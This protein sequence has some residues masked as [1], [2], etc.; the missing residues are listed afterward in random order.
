MVGNRQ[1]RHSCQLHRKA[2]YFACFTGLPLL[3]LARKDVSDQF[4]PQQTLHQATELKGRI[5]ALCIK[6]GASHFQVG[7]DYPYL[8]TR[9]RPVRE[10]LTGLK[11]L[12]DPQKLMNPGALGLD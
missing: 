2:E 11:L 12:L 7:K 9:K 10:L 1:V 6:N 5:Q 4:K 8:E 3:V